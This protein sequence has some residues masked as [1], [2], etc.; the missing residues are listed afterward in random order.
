MH[1]ALQKFVTE[2]LPSIDNLH[3]AL[4]QKEDEGTRMVLEGFMKV[5]SKF[6]IS[7]IEP[8]IGESFNPHEHEALT[9][10]ESLEQPHN[11]I[12]SVLQP[13]YKLKDRLLRPSRVI[14]AVNHN[15]DDNS[16]E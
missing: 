6:E 8:N 7:I 1:F 3:Y 5:F 15:K 12:T 11:T 2:L 13:G 16:H 4:K 14:V 10:Q 9:M